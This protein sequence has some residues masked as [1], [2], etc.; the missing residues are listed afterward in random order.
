MRASNFMVVVVAAALIL[1]SGA[2]RADKCDDVESKVAADVEAVI[3]S[4][5]VAC[6]E[7][8]HA[9]SQYRLGL[10][11]DVIGISIIPTCGI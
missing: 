2:A 4:A 9:K 8:G 6:A 1:L 10:L 5:L 11:F 3:S 7:K